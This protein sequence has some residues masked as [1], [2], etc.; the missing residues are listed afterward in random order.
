MG[1][2]SYK[3]P[4]QASQVKIRRGVRDDALAA[5]R[6]PSRRRGHPWYRPPRHTTLLAAFH[7]GQHEEVRQAE[8][9]GNRR[10]RRRQAQVRYA[11]RFLRWHKRAVRGRN[12][13]KQQQRRRKWYFKRDYK[14]GQQ[15]REKYLMGQCPGAS[16]S[17][18]CRRQR[19]QRRFPGNGPQREQPGKAGWQVHCWRSNQ[20]R[21][22]QR[23]KPFHQHQAG[24]QRDGGQEEG[25]FWNTKKRCWV[26]TS[27][28]TAEMRQEASMRLR[29]MNMAGL[30]SPGMCAPHNTTQYI[31]DQHEFP[32][33]NEEEA[34]A[35]MSGGSGNYSSADEDFP[36]TVQED[37]GTSTEEEEEESTQPA[38]CCEI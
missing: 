19:C 11:P 3:A 21:Q 26:T 14:L 4:S 24:G 7:V 17:N 35:A 38:I 27:Y 15:E 13:W 6:H 1:R 30:C 23:T 25:L 9:R 8:G 33:R 10:R 32:W 16:F 5:K 29:S 20:R 37:E 34:A 12:R 22:Q 36:L 31:M 2:A 18:V 28:L